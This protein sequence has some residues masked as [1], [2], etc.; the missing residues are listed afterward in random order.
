VLVS[1]SRTNRA[2]LAACLVAVSLVA[3]CRQQS[4]PATGSPKGAAGR[5]VETGDSELSLPAGDLKPEQVAALE[6]AVDKDPENLFA[7]NKLLI[8]YLNSGD[9]VVGQQATIAARRRHIVWLIQHHP[10]A[11][12]TRSWG[13]RIFTAPGDQDPDPVGY[14]EGRKLWLAQVERPDTAVSILSGAARFFRVND[15]PLAEKMLLRAQALEPK[16]RW[17][18][19]LG[20]LY[21]EILVGANATTAQGVVRSVSL[22]DAHGAYAKEIRRKLTLSTDV[23]LLV[24]TAESLGQWGRTLFENH[25]IDFDPVALAR[26]YLEKALQLDP[27]SILAHQVAMNVR[28]L[29]RGG[30]LAII[31]QGSSLEAQYRVLAALP[32]AQRYLRMSLLAEAAYTGAEQVDASRHNPAAA[33]AEFETART[34]AQEALQLAPKFRND[35]DYGTAI[36]N[37]NMVLG[38]LAMRA[39]NRKAAVQFMLDAS[40]AP[41]TE[42]LAYSMTDF[43]LKLPEWLFR[44]GERDSVAEFLERFSQMNVSE[45]GYLQESAKAIRSGKK[46][47]WVQK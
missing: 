16:G 19:E 39:G 22:A 47:L 35:P 11:K 27:Q 5:P 29:D 21:Y 23:T 30:Q 25:S 31:P 9:K 41:G 17:S 7:R 44:D 13:A 1:S 36:Y 37:A 24:T 46:P 2:I 20:R 10:E 3:G 8:F 38:L 14:E 33:K 6:A 28:F 12:A 34:C 40:K 4:Q 15:K 43:S 45:K 18:G 32:E 26:T 42:E